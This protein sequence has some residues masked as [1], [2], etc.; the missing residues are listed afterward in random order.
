[1]PAEDRRQP[2]PASR[3]GR[4]ARQRPVRR[5]SP[6]SRKS[7]R[8]LIGIAVTVGA[9]A[10]L[11]WGVPALERL[12]LLPHLPHLPRSFPAS[13]L[14]LIA[15]LLLFFAAAE[16]LLLAGALLTLR[17]PDRHQ[18]ILFLMRYW[19]L[20]L[21]MPAAILLNRDLGFWSITETAADPAPSAPAQQA[22]HHVRRTRRRTTEMI[23]P[24][25]ALPAAN[26]STAEIQPTSAPG[27]AAGWS[28]GDAVTP[29][30]YRQALSLAIA[31]LQEVQ[32][33]LKLYVGMFMSSERDS[34][35]AE[36]PPSSPPSSAPAASE[37]PPPEVR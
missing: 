14:A 1:M 34:Q 5:R 4:R 37:Y 17:K 23:R 28:A 8:T 25:T 29:D 20:V 16:G 32:K 6:R 24:D 35:P 13:V 9:W 21:V 7:V 22:G 3:P 10:G 31:H 27:P 36:L 19:P 15:G 33:E 11:H 12:S 30:E 18:R 2:T 26:A